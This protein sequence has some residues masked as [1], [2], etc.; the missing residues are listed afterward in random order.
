MDAQILYR[1]QAPILFMCN[2]LLLGND[3]L[4]LCFPDRIE[5]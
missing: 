5:E 3:G 2:E 1:I 4:M